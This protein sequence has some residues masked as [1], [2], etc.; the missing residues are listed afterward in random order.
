MVQSV[1][2]AA[3]S[4]C[5]L[6][7]SVVKT[8]GLQIGW[9]SGWELGQLP[10]DFQCGYGVGIIHAGIIVIRSLFGVY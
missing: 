2:N 1:R 7:G 10:S 3:R 5:H 4:V 6:V 9:F 8:S